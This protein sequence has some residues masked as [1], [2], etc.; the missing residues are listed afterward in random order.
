MSRITDTFERLKREG[1]AGLITYL[2]AGDPDRETSQALLN[3][4]PAAG[5]D[6]VEMGMCFSDPMADGPTIQ[7]A[8]RRALLAGNTLAETLE[9]A[10]D[11]RNHNPETPL[12]LMGYFNP[13]YKYGC[14]DFIDAASVAGVDGLIIVDLPP[15]EGDEIAPF[16]QE[17]GID[18]IRLV[19]PV[20]DDARLD[21][22]ISNASG[23][24]YYV[25]ITGV[26]GAAASNT[27]DVCAHVR[28][29]KQKTGL[30]VAVGFGIKTPADAA[31]FKDAAD[32]IV[33]G[34]ALVE[35]I[36]KNPATASIEITHKVTALRQSL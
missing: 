35:E 29:I 16:A 3:A 6:I 11:F 2:A 9:M 32:G 21:T 4:L 27:D 18:L 8:T 34:S 30:P 19:T 5:A 7:A 24:L 12:V 14:A 22:L 13:V 36:G 28:K 25:S 23:F 17:K 33:V 10:A 1:R 15:E 31:A 26:T 20:T